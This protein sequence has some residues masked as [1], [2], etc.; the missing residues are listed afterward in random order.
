MAAISLFLT[1]IATN[2][3][4]FHRWDSCTADLLRVGIMSYI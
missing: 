1:G 4:T 2:R 3:E